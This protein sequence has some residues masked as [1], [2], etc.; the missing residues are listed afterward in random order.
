MQ[1]GFH[2]ALRQ[3]IEENIAKYVEVVT[4]GRAASFEEYREH[5]GYL[6]AMRDALDM[7]IEVEERLYPTNPLKRED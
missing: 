6:R 5:V 1:D 4:R 3:R 7:C 2:S